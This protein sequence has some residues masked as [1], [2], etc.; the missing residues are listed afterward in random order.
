MAR[1]RKG[2]SKRSERMRELW[3]NPET[4]ERY[5]QSITGVTR[6]AESRARISEGAKKREQQFAQDPVAYAAL[7]KRRNEASI[8]S[9]LSK[10]K[11][12][13]PCVTC[14]APVLKRQ[15]TTCGKP[16]CTFAQKSR[17]GI[18]S[19]G[20]KYRPQTEA[21]KE[22]K[23]IAS[24]ANWQSPEYRDKV[25][26]RAAAAVRTPEHRAKLSILRQSDWA[27][28]PARAAAWAAKAT[29]NSHYARYP[30]VCRNGRPFVFKSGPGWELSFAE[31]LDAKGFVWDYEPAVIHLPTGKRYIPDFWIE[32]LQT[33]VELKASHRDTL[34]ADLVYREGGAIFILQGTKDMNRFLSGDW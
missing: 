9:R 31:W 28:D 30:Y 7:V 8:A 19:R 13:P 12:F 14:G 34:K 22:A 10:R 21:E 27:A 32:E 5:V 33:F 17:V 23:R 16:E 4:R 15:R 29:R 6:S 25:T 1:I 2:G 24:R 20:N 18:A 26:T 11:P 3:A